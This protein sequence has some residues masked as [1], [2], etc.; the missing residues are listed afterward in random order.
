[1][2][3]NVYFFI[4]KGGVGKSTCSAIF[5]YQQAKQGKNVIINSIDPAHNLSDIFKKSLSNKVS[6]I[7]N[8]LF[9]LETDINI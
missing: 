7:T 3:N 9:A 2:D 8:N 1:M 6:K 4:G 5:A